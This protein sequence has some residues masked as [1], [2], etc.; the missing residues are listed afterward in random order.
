MALLPTSFWARQ[1]YFPDTLAS[2]TNKVLT[3]Y[4]ETMMQ[5]LLIIQSMQNGIDNNCSIDEIIQ[6]CRPVCF[7]RW[8]LIIISAF[9][10]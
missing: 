5:V 9:G 7:I 8:V 4:E 2:P 6:L 10:S 1:E 3:V